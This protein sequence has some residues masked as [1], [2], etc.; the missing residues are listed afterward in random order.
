M[1]QKFTRMLF[2]VLLSMAGTMSYG[3]SVAAGTDS[4]RIKFSYYMQDSVVHFIDSSSCSSSAV[5]YKWEFGDGSSSV[6]KNPSHVYARGVYQANVCLT[7]KNEYNI[8]STACKVIMVRGSDSCYAGFNY[9]MQKDS[10]SSGFKIYF[11]DTSSPNV[12]SRMWNFGDGTSS[13]IKDPVHTYL[14]PGAT[15]EVSLIVNTSFGCMD[16][17]KRIITIPNITPQRECYANFS[18]ISTK[19]SSGLGIMVTFKDMSSPN[20]ISR[21]WNFGDGTSS[22][23]TNPSHRYTLPQGT[24]ITVWEFVKTSVNCYDSVSKTVM[25]P[26][27]VPGDTC[28]AYFNYIAD[29]DTAGAAVTVYFTDQSSPNVINRHWDFGDG[30]SS[31]IKN[32][33]HRY[34]LPTGSVVNIRE[35]VTTS[36]G[37]MDTISRRLHIVYPYR[38][39][40]C[41]A[42]FT[43]AQDST[44]SSGWGYRFTNLSSANATSYYWDFGDGTSSVMKDPMHVYR[45][46]S[47]TQAV[48]T[49]RITTSMYCTDTV[50]KIIALPQ[51]ANNYFLSGKV[52]VK[53]TPLSS[54]IVA[55]YKKN[56]INRYILK[57]ANVITNGSF[58]FEQLEAGKYIIC[59]IPDINNSD[60][61]LPTYYVNS[62]HWSTA[63]EIDLKSNAQGLTLK[64]MAVKSLTAGV[65]S[66]SGNVIENTF[67]AT[68]ESSLK[69]ATQ[70]TYNVYLYSASGEI[71]SSATPDAMGNF[72]FQNLPY[73]NY[74]LNVEYPNYESRSMT[75][76]LTQTTPSVNNIQ[77]SVDRLALAVN[78]VKDENEI[79]VYYVSA[80]QIAVRVREAGKYNVSV[81]SITGSILYQNNAL[82][83]DANTD[84]IIDLK[85]IPAGTYLL[86]MQN[87]EGLLV[88][89]LA[90]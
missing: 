12:I 57:D 72:S 49:L 48:V 35:I 24:A 85:N 69:S 82:D 67:E 86:K 73:G 37:C 56:S 14:V 17:V 64:M 89:K 83:F 52:M 25:I 15:V 20:V 66:I 4:C 46:V 45:L 32:P 80:N 77:F 11:M 58:K 41:Y 71:I 70:V 65:G 19:D 81:V 51:I 61:C 31:V 43:Y 10:M 39:D 47:G 55:L 88:K 5:S 44:V 50:F 2:V 90:K 30:T 23:L 63:N 40:S 8:S 7:V 29:Y 53:T 60:K 27:D 75:V 18:Y 42:N 87:S 6:L 26:Y 68:S 22:V 3:A 76:N 78:P 79:T 84:K 38:T 62:L 21:R 16:T 54:G 34:T 1:S 74:S 33:V 28:V 9:Y 36:L 59:A 13:A